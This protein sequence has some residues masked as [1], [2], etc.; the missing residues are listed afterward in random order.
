M[1]L[2]LWSGS[3]YRPAFVIQPH[4][5]TSCDVLEESK[6]H[7]KELRLENFKPEN[8]AAEIPAYLH[9]TVTSLAFINSTTSWDWIQGN[10]LRFEFLNS[11]SF[12]GVTLKEE[13]GEGWFQTFDEFKGFMEFQKKLVNLT[14]VSPC[15]FSLAFML[16]KLRGE[17]LCVVDQ[18]NPRTI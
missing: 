2:K 14:I 18:C 1:I 3:A 13:R 11:L 8:S 4:P 10:I 6:V 5:A 17:S 15:L 9:G 7:W 12:L 16:E